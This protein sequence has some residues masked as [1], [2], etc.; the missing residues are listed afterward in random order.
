MIPV[1][2][3]LF[4]GL[5]MFALFVMANAMVIRWLRRSPAPTGQKVIGGV[6]GFG[7]LA[8][9]GLVGLALFVGTLGLSVGSALIAHGPVRAIEVVRLDGSHS[10]PE[11]TGDWETQAELEAYRAAVADLDPRYPV[12]V[13]V[14]YRGDVRVDRLERW[15]RQKSDGEVRLLDVEPVQGQEG[16]VRLD[17]GVDISPRELERLEQEFEESQPFFDLPH[18]L[19]IDVRQP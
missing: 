17:F 19:R 14:E 10:L 11:G 7:A 3:V 13:L 12:H 6:A 16:L 1:L 2:L 5:G 18:A 15:I 9:A 8:L 4:L